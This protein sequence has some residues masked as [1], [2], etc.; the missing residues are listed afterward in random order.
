M[1]AM[2]AASLEQFLSRTA[3]RRVRFPVEAGKEGAC[4]A[5]WAEQFESL[6]AARRRGVGFK[7]KKRK[8][9]A[10]GE[11]AADQYGARFK[12]GARVADT[13]LRAVPFGGE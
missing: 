13:D 5:A 6:E 12:R 10:L 8:S 4:D 11:G 2:D 7:G 3:R 1:C 9:E